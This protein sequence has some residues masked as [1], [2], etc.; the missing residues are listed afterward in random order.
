MCMAAISVKIIA[1]ESKC[2]L[3][4]IRGN[5]KVFGGTEQKFSKV[6]CFLAFNS[7]FGHI[8]LR[9]DTVITDGGKKQT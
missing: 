5:P 2:A 3:D 7:G 4:V 8:V 6:D 9:L 1:K